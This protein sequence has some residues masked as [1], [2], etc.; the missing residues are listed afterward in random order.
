MNG[1]EIC[2]PCWKQGPSVHLALQHHR[3]AHSIPSEQLAQ[4][5]SEQ[6]PSRQARETNP[7]L[8]CSC[9]QGPQKPRA[10]ISAD[11]QI[12]GITSRWRYD[13]SYAQ[14]HWHLVSVTC[15][16][17]DM[18]VCICIYIYIYICRYTYIHTYI[19]IYTHMY[20]YVCIYIYIYT[21]TWGSD[22]TFNNYTFKHNLDFNKHIEWQYCICQIRVVFESTVGEIAVTAPYMNPGWRPS[23]APSGVDRRAARPGLARHFPT[24]N[25]FLAGGWHALVGLDFCWMQLYTL[26]CFVM[27]VLFLLHCV[28]YLFR[29][30]YMILLSLPSTHQFTTLSA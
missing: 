2:K 8:S 22:Y 9:M 1:A 30:N 25:G 28:F 26:I 7:S 13:I 21:H 15:M 12:Y 20:V 24:Q 11:R 27:F 4:E 3:A 23:L 19:H 29:C 17:V 10:Y 6:T 16:H 5:N 18:C 14:W